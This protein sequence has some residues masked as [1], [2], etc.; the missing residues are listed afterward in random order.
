MWEN[1]PLDTYAFID[2][3]FR[4]LHIKIIKCLTPMSVVNN[5]VFLFSLPNSKSVADKVFIDCKVQK[6]NPPEEFP[7][8]ILS[9]A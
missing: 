8:A 2:D 5:T 6:M 3:G 9:H 7:P 1:N 4:A